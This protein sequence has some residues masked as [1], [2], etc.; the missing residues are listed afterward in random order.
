M[1]ASR[2]RARVWA[3]AGR[4]VLFVVVAAALA[5]AAEA[6][7]SSR[8]ISVRH[9]SNAALGFFVSYPASWSVM[10]VSSSDDS[11]AV[12][13]GTDGSRVNVQLGVD[14]LRGSAFE[15]AT[16]ADLSNLLQI[17][18]DGPS[19]S[20]RTGFVS[21]AGLRLAEVEFTEGSTHYLL[22][23]SKGS[24]AQVK[25]LAIRAVCPTSL[26]PT[27]RAAATAIIHS[28]ETRV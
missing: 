22:L 27:R 12:V 2:R 21:V 20:L 17:S 24:N 25:Y 13:I 6:C 16:K 5:I 14:H 15:D 9:Y 19:K 8:P 4:I 1:S 3:R 28:L 23:S 7:D 18:R 11:W 10:K 26:W